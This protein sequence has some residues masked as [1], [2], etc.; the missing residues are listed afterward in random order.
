MYDASSDARK[1]IAFAT[2]SAVPKRASGICLSI[3]SWTSFG[4]ML[5]R[6]VGTKPGATAFAVM[7]RL[8]ISR[9]TVLVNAMSPAFAAL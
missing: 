6:S 8:A 3:A 7:F 2:S 4:T 1:A 5:V 9:A